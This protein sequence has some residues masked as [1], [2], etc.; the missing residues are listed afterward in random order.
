MLVVWKDSDVLRCR[1]YLLKRCLSCFHRTYY[2][3]INSNSLLSQWFLFERI[4]VFFFIGIII[5]E[6]ILV[7]LFGMIACW[8][9]FDVFHWKYCLSKG[10]LCCF[11]GIIIHESI[12]A[13][14][15]WRVSYAFCWKY[16]LL[17][18]FLCVFRRNYSLWLDSSV[19]FF[20]M[21]V[22]WAGIIVFL[23]WKYYLLKWFLCFFSSELLF[24][25]R[26]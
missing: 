4:I 14:V 10:V 13:I 24:M 19:F 2:L 23:R 9:D 21:V 6:S 5:C 16:Y 8:R 3:W 17:K 18:G 22:F 25:N 12:L 15:L 20:G 1:C 11:A 7:F 26:F